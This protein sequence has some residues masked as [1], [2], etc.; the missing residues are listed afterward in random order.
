MKKLLILSILSLGLNLK[1][2]EIKPVIGFS[3]TGGLSYGMDHEYPSVL[4]GIYWD[5]EEEKYKLLSSIYF[6]AEFLVDENKS[7]SKL[8]TNTSADFGYNSKN[9]IILN[10]IFLKRLNGGLGL[11]FNFGVGCTFSSEP[12]FK[13]GGGVTMMKDLSLKRWEKDFPFKFGLNWD[14]IMGQ[15]HLSASVYFM[16][17]DLMKKNRK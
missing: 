13:I 6:N 1:S 14:S 8:E 10:G 15:N 5:L 17:D 16:V 11:N 2:Q 4:A 3:Y 12:I 7:F 9:A